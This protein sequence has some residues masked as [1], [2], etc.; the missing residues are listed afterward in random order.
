MSKYRIILCTIPTNNSNIKI[1]PI[2]KL[3]IFIITESHKAWPTLILTIKRKPKVSIRTIS[4][5]SSILMRI[6][7]IPNDRFG[8]EKL[9]KLFL[10]KRIFIKKVVVQTLK[11]ITKTLL[12]LTESQFILPG[13]LNT[14]V[15]TKTK[16]T[17]TLISIN[18]GKPLKTIFNFEKTKPALQRIPP[19]LDC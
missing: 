9:I 12:G 7:P 4:D 17:K 6:I 11:L 14:L 10:E 5:I 16:A 3:E 2:P 8:I 13:K 18:T 19:K 15:L 1:K